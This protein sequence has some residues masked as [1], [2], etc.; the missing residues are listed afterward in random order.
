[1]TKIFKASLI[2]GPRRIMRD[3][4]LAQRKLI[5]AFK[6]KAFVAEREGDELCVYLISGDN[7]GTGTFGDRGRSGP[8]TA[9]Q[10]QERIVAGRERNSEAD[11]R[12]ALERIGR[13]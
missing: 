5:C 2:D 4:E 1:M 11:A 8:M 9:A 6:G 7:I 10:F 13:R 3:S 12:S